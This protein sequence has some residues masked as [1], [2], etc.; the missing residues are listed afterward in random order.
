MTSSETTIYVRKPGTRPPEDRSLIG[1]RLAAVAD[2]VTRIPPPGVA[3]PWPSP[4]ALAA[5]VLIDSIKRSSP[6]TGREL[7]AAL[8]SANTRLARLNDD[9]GYSELF[10]ARIDDLA[11]TVGAAATTSASTVDWAYIADCGVAVITAEGSLRHISP[12]D[13]APIRPLLPSSELSAYERMWT[14]RDLYRN[15]PA[16]PG[17]GVLTGEAAALRYIRAGQWP[18]VPGD[19]VVVFSDGC[20]PLILRKDIRRIIAAGGDAEGLMNQVAASLSLTDEVSAA[21]LAVT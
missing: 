6:S 14:I 21:V 10:T 9:L 4:A 2:G 11:G 17:F 12:D 1:P 8:A 3:Y 5:D 13:I 20:R 18:K 7:V 15:T 19:C 16:G